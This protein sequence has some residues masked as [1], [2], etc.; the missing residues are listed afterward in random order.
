MSFPNDFALDGA[1]GDDVWLV[2]A[3]TAGN[4]IGTADYALFDGALNGV[5][6]GRE[7]SNAGLWYFYP[8]ADLT[9]GA[10]NS[11][12]RVSPVVISEVQYNPGNMVGADDFE[13]VELQNTTGQPIDLSG[14]R[15]RKG[16]D[17]DFAPG[18]TLGP[19]STLVVLSFDPNDP[20]N[21]V[22]VVTF[23]NN[24][25]IDESVQLAGPYADKLSNGGERVQLQRPDDPPLEDPTYTPHMLA[26]EIDYSDVAPWPTAADGT[27]S[28]LTRQAADLWGDQPTSWTAAA[29]TPGRVDIGAA[30]VAARSIFYNNSWFDGNLA[31]A[32]VQDDA[33]IATDKTPLFPGQ[34]A[35]LA[36]Y[37][38]YSL[39]I[40]GIMVDLV[41]AAQ[42][43]L[44][45]AADFAFEVGNSSDAAT[46]IPRRPPRK[47]SSAR[48][49]AAWIA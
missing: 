3:D 30:A 28:S 16:V 23:Q 39:G 29:P 37:T 8:Q 7:Q 34:I 2:R 47:S 19:R 32:N 45:T 10:D 31:A 9:L 35:S 48:W 22:R 20:A 27:G 15:L 13:F 26:D 38:S 36:N 46:W 43:S 14:W 42:A 25:G 41:G 18:T 5:S 21:A 40:N 33:A 4:A 11:G 44:I 1:K 49:A 12:P 24:Y 6:F 17:F